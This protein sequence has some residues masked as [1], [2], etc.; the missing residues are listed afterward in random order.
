MGQ[1]SASA[2]DA[3]AKRASAGSAITRAEVPSAGTTNASYFF[4][5]GPFR[6]L[7]NSL[8][9]GVQEFINLP[10]NEQNAR[11]GIL[12][13]SRGVRPTGLSRQFKQGPHAGKVSRPANNARRIAQS[14][15]LTQEEAI[16]KLK[17]KIRSG[18]TVRKT[19]N[20]FGTRRKIISETA[21]QY[22]II[23]LKRLASN[24]KRDIL[25]KISEEELRML[26]EVSEN[27]LNGAIG[28]G[29]LYELLKETG[30]TPEHTHVQSGEEI[31]AIM[32]D[33]EQQEQLADMLLEL[34][35]NTTELPNYTLAEMIPIINELAST[36]FR[37]HDI[38]T[39]TVQLE[40]VV[41]MSV[42]RYKDLLSKSLGKNLL[43][44]VEDII[45]NLACA[46]LSDNTILY[47][48]EDGNRIVKDKFIEVLGS[49]FLVYVKSI[50][51]DQETLVSFQNIDLTDVL[52]DVTQCANIRVIEN[53]LTNGAE[54]TSVGTLAHS[55]L[56]KTANR[57]LKIL[58]RVIDAAGLIHT[59]EAPSLTG[60]VQTAI[61]TIRGVLDSTL[62]RLVNLA[63]SIAINSRNTPVKQLNNAKFRDILGGALESIVGTTTDPAEQ[64][65]L[66]VLSRTIIE[67]L[68][69]ARTVGDESESESLSQSNNEGGSL[70][71][72]LVQKV[73]KFIISCVPTEAAFELVVP[74]GPPPQP[75][76]PT[77]EEYRILQRRLNAAKTV[78][79]RHVQGRR[80]TRNERR[81][82][83]RSRERRPGNEGRPENRSRRNRNRSR[84]SR[85]RSRNK[86]NI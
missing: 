65:D 63:H 23:L 79:G 80:Q 21:K 42:G 22:A 55:I 17:E 30:H 15:T 9:P 83:N 34:I 26:R 13:R 8:R 48:T 54:G 77:E 12:R 86:K 6:W 16:Q 57:S 14:L 20:M 47:R 32:D 37:L 58:G 51:N 2:G 33:V 68:D 43:I 36:V 38:A 81:P 56:S 46:V 28:R 35:R 66:R 82:R 64:H 18:E 24:T 40:G 60:V 19:V 7:S 59:I 85:S 5:R 71:Q 29:Y 11:E 10:L 31:K 45:I 84:R 74:P 78:S 75:E 76:P 72:K 50:T 39:R 49:I 67:S 4:S 70:S 25:L 73:D 53:F 41:N 62:Q 3:S 61:G 44:D 69:D 1:S 52:N 27:K